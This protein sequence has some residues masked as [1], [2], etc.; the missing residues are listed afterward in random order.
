MYVYMRVFA[1]GQ[2]LSQKFDSRAARVCGKSL[3]LMVSNSIFWKQTK[4]P[5]KGDLRR[6]SELKKI[7]KCSA[8]S[9]K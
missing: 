7:V 2:T 3:R 5:L 4:R 9:E 1:C 6:Q 8:K